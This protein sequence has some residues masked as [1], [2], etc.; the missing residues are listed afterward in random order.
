MTSEEETS[1]RGLRLCLLEMFL[2]S[3]VCR[4][5][6]VNTIS[7]PRL[8]RVT[9]DLPI[10]PICLIC[11]LL[12][13]SHFTHIITGFSVSASE[14]TY[15]FKG[16]WDTPQAEVHD[17]EYLGISAFKK[18]GNNALGQWC[19]LRTAERGPGVTELFSHL[20]SPAPREAAIPSDKT[21]GIRA[22]KVQLKTTHWQHTNTHMTHTLIADTD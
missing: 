3:C 20:S 1:E 5:L 6:R 12:L 17:E 7:S 19:H 13:L 9:L 18:S 21:G 15:I 16:S 4:L 14:S 10:L 11:W 2:R 22:L 8:H